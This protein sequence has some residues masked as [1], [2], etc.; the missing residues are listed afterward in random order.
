MICFNY[1]LNELIFSLFKLRKLGSNVNYSP[2]WVF[3]GFDN[4]LVVPRGGGYTPLVVQVM[5]GMQP[6][7][8][9]WACVKDAKLVC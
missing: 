9:F 1:H 6:R 8:H 3:P 4:K 5:V 7:L 2:V